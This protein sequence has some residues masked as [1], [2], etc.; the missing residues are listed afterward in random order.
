MPVQAIDLKAT[1]AQPSWANADGAMTQA[2]ATT[3]FQRCIR[4]STTVHWFNE[5][6]R[7]CEHE[8]NEI[9]RARFP[10]ADEIRVEPNLIFS[11]ATDA[12]P[13]Y[14]LQSSAEAQDEESQGA[15]PGA[16]GGAQ[17]AN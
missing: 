4:T 6:T 7:L 13:V 15:T 10:V 1:R 8:L 17:G 3:G 9:D 12:R 11:R 5:W 16:E 2:I 14:S